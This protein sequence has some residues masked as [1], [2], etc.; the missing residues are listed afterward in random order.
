MSENATTDLGALGT[1]GEFVWDEPEQNQGVDT[2]A[3]DGHD[4]SLE[5][6]NRML[7]P[8]KCCDFSSTYRYPRLS[9][10]AKC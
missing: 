5:A 7:L 2:D 8:R 3:R 9:L 6:W 4:S 1:L 10:H